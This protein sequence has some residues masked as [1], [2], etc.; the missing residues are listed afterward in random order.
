MRNLT[1]L[2]CFIRYTASS[3][4]PLRN[5]SSLKNFEIQQQNTDT[6]LSFEVMNVYCVGTLF[7]TLKDINVFVS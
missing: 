7:K 1:I 4:R 2:Q 6:Y 5:Y 3:L